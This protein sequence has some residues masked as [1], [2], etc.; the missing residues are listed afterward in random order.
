MLVMGEAF[1]GATKFR[2]IAGAPDHARV[3]ETNFKAE[4]GFAPGW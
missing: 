2:A 4:F 1:R 3:I